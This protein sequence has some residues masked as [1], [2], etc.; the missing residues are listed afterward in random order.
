MYMD[1][2]SVDYNIINTKQYFRYSQKFNEKKAEND[3]K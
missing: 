3:I 2:C 1:M